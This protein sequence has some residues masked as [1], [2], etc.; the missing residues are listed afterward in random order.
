MRTVVILLLSI[1]SSV[2]ATREARAGVDLASVVSQ[3]CETNSEP[4][5][6]RAAAGRDAKA[7]ARLAAFQDLC[8]SHK[9]DWARLQGKQYPRQYFMVQY[10]IDVCADLQLIRVTAD[11]DMQETVAAVC[12]TQA[13][14]ETGATSF[15]GAGINMVLGLGDLLQAEAKQEALEYL[16]ER[17]GKR[18]CQ[19]SFT[20]DLPEPRTDTGAVPDPRHVIAMSVWF[21]NSCAV[22]LPDGAIDVEAFTFGALKAAFKQDLR[23]LPA[24]IAVPAQAWVERHWSGAEPYIAAVGVAMYVLYDVLQGMT[25][26]EILT[27]LGDKADDALKGKVRCDLTT[28]SKITKECVLLLGFDLARAA[29]IGYTRDRT[30]S[31]SRIIGDALDKFCADF[32]ATGMQEQGGCVVARDDYEH[33]HARL[34]AIYRAIKRMQ[35]LD[36]TMAQMASESTRDEISKRVAAEIVHAIRQ[37][38][39]ALAA[40]TADALPDDRAKIVDDFA[41]LDLAFDAFDAIVADDPAALGR[42]LLGVLSSKLGKK[43][44]P[45]EVVHALTVVIALASAKDREEVKGILKDVTAPVGTYRRKYGAE[46]VMISLNGFVGFFVGEELRTNGRNPDGTPRDAFTHRAPWKLAAPVGIDFSLVSGGRCLAFW[47]PGKCNHVGIVATLI[48]PLALEVSTKNDTLSADWKTLFEP[49]VYVRFGLLHSPFT[50]AIG[51]NYQW[52][53]RSDEMCGTERCFDGAFQFGALLSADVPLF[54]LR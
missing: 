37:L 10:G 21:K 33:W 50:L 34:L 25:P 1:A 41:L 20:I 39:D 43:K 19:Y 24:H 38:I 5:Y 3:R 22:M 30:T 52:A 35:E 9:V 2:V 29:A 36:R 4:E 31:P 26:L 46:S 13:T 17:I 47:R 14:R 23:A 12:G 16:L 53:R 48:D 28:R 42:T 51:A 11:I 44:V 18:F 49:G 32:G 40:A 15:A 8:L 7:K 6:R 45:A 54:V 27:D